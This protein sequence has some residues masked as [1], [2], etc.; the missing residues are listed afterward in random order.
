MAARGPLAAA[1]RDRLFASSA[2]IAEITF[3]Q[4]DAS[5]INMTAETQF[6][7]RAAFFFRVSYLILISR[8]LYSS[9]MIYIPPGT[10]SES[11]EPVDSALFAGF[12]LYFST[13]CS[14]M[15]S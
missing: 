8:F 2:R 11:G 13:V 15:L 5:R 14:A 12:I 3:L 10:G 9:A 1:T 4:V 6:A 7:G